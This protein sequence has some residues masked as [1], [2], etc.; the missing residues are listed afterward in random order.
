MS[1]SLS[2]PHLPQK[3]YLYT[4]YHQKVYNK[5]TFKEMKKYGGKDLPENL[6]GGVLKFL[7][8]YVPTMASGHFLLLV[9]I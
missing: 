6:G 1:V 5:E 4:A 3:H 9:P 7:L 8:L 2:P